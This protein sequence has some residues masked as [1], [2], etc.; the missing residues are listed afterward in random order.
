MWDPK[1]VMLMLFFAAHVKQ[2][3]AHKQQLQHK[4]VMM[5]LCFCCC[6]AAKSGSQ[7]SQIA[8]IPPP[9]DDLLL[10]TYGR[11]VESL[12][13]GHRST[14]GDIHAHIHVQREL[15]SLLGELSPENLAFIL[16][17]IAMRYK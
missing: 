8:Q 14:V 3:E 11:H 15:Y 5:L 17:N 2:Q 9:N 10:R 7:I 12:I 4:D 1:H 16:L 6:C 13:E